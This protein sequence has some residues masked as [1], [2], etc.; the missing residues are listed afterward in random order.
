MPCALRAWHRWLPP[1]TLPWICLA[2]VLNTVPLG[3]L[4]TRS[5][6]E[7]H[8]LATSSYLAAQRLRWTWGV[9]RI[10]LRHGVRASVEVSDRGGYRQLGTSLW[11]TET[12]PDAGLGVGGCRLVANS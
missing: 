12:R 3:G 10:D 2:R 6:F 4:R 8:A 5:L 9:N 7:L 11:V 1:G